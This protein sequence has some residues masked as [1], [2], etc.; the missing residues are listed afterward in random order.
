MTKKF[1]TGGGLRID[2]LITHDGKAYTG[3]PGGNALFSAVGAS[4]WTKNVGLWAR[5]GENYPQ[6]W[7]DEL[8]ERGLDTTGLIRVPGDQDH[9]T[10]FAYTPD[11]RRDDTNPA[12]HF[13]RIQQP[14]PPALTDYLHSTPGQDDPYVYEPLALRPIDWPIA[15]DDATAVHLSPHSLRS[16][17][18]I[19]ATLRQFGVRQ[20]TVDPGERYMVPELIPHLATFLPHIDAFLPSREEIHSLMGNGV[21]MEEAATT[22]GQLGA[23]L[24]I[25]KMGAEGVLVSEGNGRIT[26]LPPYHAPNDER[27]V[28]VTGAGDAFCGGFMVGLATTHDPLLAA[29]MGMVSAS[30]ILEGY[31]ALTALA[32][33]PTEARKRLKALKTKKPDRLFLACQV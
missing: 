16:H 17:M 9:R 31:G 15:Y 25:I 26:H 5:L 19:P 30:F 2:Y 24:V 10:F 13:R 21:S 1:I 18:Y 14:L 20:I 29:K 6:H 11:G 12:A 27:V 32:T 28:D 23:R 22:L 4:I 7:L 33:S 3:L 8:A